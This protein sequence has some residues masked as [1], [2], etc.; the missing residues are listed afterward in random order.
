[1]LLDLEMQKALL[2]WARFTLET[3]LKDSSIP[4]PGLLIKK[5]SQAV[6]AFVTLHNQ[7]ELRGCM[8][9]II[10]SDPLWKTIQEMAIVAATQDT[11]F[12]SVGLGELEEIDIEIS[13][14]T[15]FQKVE[16]LDEIQV[17]VHGL[18][19][20]QGT[21]RG[22][23]LPQVASEEGWSPEE[24]LAH[25][26]IKADLPAEAWLDTKTKIEIFSAQVFGE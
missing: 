3:Y 26:C 11:R 19:I 9:R 12:D 16:D 21:H 22:L 13:V 8:G 4:K 7:G 20:S 24:F 25:T 5:N 15:P 10:S 23:L 18:M 14:L 2:Q 17:G 1:M 6:G